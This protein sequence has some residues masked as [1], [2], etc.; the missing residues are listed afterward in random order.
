MGP[1]PVYLSSMGPRPVETALRKPPPLHTGQ[2]PM[3]LCFAHGPGAHATK[4]VAGREPVV[5]RGDWYR[6]A[7]GL[8]AITGE[9]PL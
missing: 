5:S 7:K 6:F 8:L 4:K 2:G 9:R 3:L 1:R